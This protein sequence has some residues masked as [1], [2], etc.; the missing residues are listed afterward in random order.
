MRLRVAITGAGIAGGLTAGT[1]KP[2]T[3]V[4]LP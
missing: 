4:G 1:S 2:F 3:V